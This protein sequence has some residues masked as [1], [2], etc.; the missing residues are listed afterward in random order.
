MLCV[1]TCCVCACVCA[2]CMCVLICCGIGAIVLQCCVAV[3]EGSW[4]RGG[5][6][7]KQGPGFPS[8]TFGGPVTPDSYLLHTIRYR[9]G[10]EVDGSYIVCCI[11]CSHVVCSILMCHYLLIQLFSNCYCNL[12]F[13]FIKLSHI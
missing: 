1:F 4:R 11:C 10:S 12:T 6:G 13:V 5:G 2:C 3:L 8:V 7:G 9:C